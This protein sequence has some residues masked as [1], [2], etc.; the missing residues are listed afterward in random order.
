MNPAITVGSDNHLWITQET[1]DAPNPHTITCVKTDGMTCGEYRIPY[2]PAI[3][4]PLFRTG[5]WLWDITAADNGYLYFTERYADR[6]GCFDPR[7]ADPV[8][9]FKSCGEWLTATPHSEPFEITQA[10]DGNLYFTEYAA[11]K[12]GCLTK[13]GV[14]CGE[15]A[16]EGTPTGITVGPDNELWFTES[17][18]DKVARFSVSEHKVTAEAPVASGS[19]PWGITKGPPG[20]Y[21]VWFTERGGNKVA[22]FSVLDLDV[23]HYPPEEFLVPTANSEP[24]GITVGP[25][26]RIWFVE[27]NRS[28]PPSKIGRTTRAYP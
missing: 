16:V 3:D 1:A 14:R 24:S 13:S 21:A 15:W 8:T 19:Q 28:A 18:G 7:V 23:F 11:N 9:G 4:D 27:A 22:R 25:D 6:I 10:P 2:V 26:H 12:I 5:R 17:D 20:D